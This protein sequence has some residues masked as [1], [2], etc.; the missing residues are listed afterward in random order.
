M[1]ATYFNVLKQAYRLTKG[2]K[3]FWPLGLFLVWPNFFKNL[4]L[5][6]GLSYLLNVPDVIETRVEEGAT[7]NP[8]P[9]VAIFI[10]IVIAILAIY[11]F[12]SKAALATAVKHLRAFRK[13]ESKQVMDESEMHT[14]ELLKV[15]FSLLA[16]Y[17]LVAAIGTSP[18]AYIKDSTSMT[19]IFLAYT[20]A[21]VILVPAS[22]FAYLLSILAPMYISLHKVSITDSIRLSLDMIRRCWA[23][24]LGFGFILF[25]IEMVGVL[26]GLVLMSI[27]IMPFVFFGQLSYDVVGTVIG[28]TVFFL[29]QCLMVAFVRVAWTVMFLQMVKPDSDEKAVA[30]SV[31]ELAA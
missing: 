22:I 11:Y 8:N 28:F 19:G 24:L 27:C 2:H 1:G 20:L 25:V 29:S 6:V 17:L 9:W 3:T 21:I 18:L 26:V 30:E 12:R 14:V 31:P 10:L 7:Q 15:G 23:I 16:I 13:V 4:V 5:I